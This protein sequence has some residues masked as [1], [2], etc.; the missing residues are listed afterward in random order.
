MNKNPFLKSISFLFLILCTV[1]LII[2][3]VSNFSKGINTS[4]DSY[5]L[6]STLYF[7]DMKF[8]ISKFY[9]FFGLIFE[10]L[11]YNIYFLRVF[12][13][14]SLIVASIYFL[15]FFNI[16]NKISF[17]NSVYLCL[18]ICGINGILY[19]YHFWQLNPSYNLLNIVGFLFLTASTFALIVKSKNGI[20]TNLKYILLGVLGGVL[21]IFSKVISLV[22]FLPILLI[23]LSFYLERKFLFSVI[24]L[25][26]SFLVLFLVLFINFYFGFDNFLKDINGA[27]EMRKIMGYNN[28]GLLAMLYLNIKQIIFEII[29]YIYIF[30]FLFSL[31]IFKDKDNFKNFYSLIFLFSVCLLFF[32][33]KSLISIIFSLL[34]MSLINVYLNFEKKKNKDFIIS[35][36]F[37]SS[38]CFSISFGT[39]TG[40]VKHLNYSYFF[41]FVIL[42]NYYSTF[43]SR[44]FYENFF[45]SLMIFII[46][47]SAIIGGYKKPLRLNQS[48]SEQNYK[49]KF[50]FTSG[51]LYVDK[52]TLKKFIDIRN[53]AI[54]NGWE[55][56]NYLIDLT[57]RNPFY[58]L[59]LG[60][61]FLNH[62][63]INS[64]FNPDK[65]FEF[66]YSK[67]N[68]KN[69]QKS[70][71]LINEG[72]GFKFNSRIYNKFGINEKNF[73]RVG[74]VNSDNNFKNNKI[75]EYNYSLW[76]PK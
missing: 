16:F 26:L 4:D 8:E 20:L 57:G 47:L 29:S 15:H 50:P 49:I 38:V 42:F 22:I 55:N 58:H 67:E 63:W 74:E 45:G 23:F 59:A 76:K 52:Y 5:Y 10:Y 48:I 13:L 43:V 54:E 14:L 18:K 62:A 24:I 9:I 46:V 36:L 41:L 19:Y 17:S 39:N 75:Y 21:I 11:N 60:A 27:Y 30:L 64:A 34:I 35:L 68:Y 65:S 61:K 28:S 44:N 51:V 33:T 40:I 72:R 31:V 70:W 1:S 3:L 37:L 12:G 69:I 73:Q 53:L 7:E 25:S 66:F 2:F 32:Y 56:G 71:L 6:L